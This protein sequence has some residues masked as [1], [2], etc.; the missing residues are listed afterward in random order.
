[1]RF[2]NGGIFLNARAHRL[3]TIALAGA[4]ICGALMFLFPLA[5]ELSTYQIDAAEY[6]SIAEVFKPPDNTPEIIVP[7]ST[8]IASPTEDPIGPEGTTA[9]VAATPVAKVA[10]P[11]TEELKVPE[12]TAAGV[13]ATPATEETP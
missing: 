12:V 6:A 1:M 10:V 4:F 9:E 8:A 5:A 11:S 3:S 13:T 2:L 7:A